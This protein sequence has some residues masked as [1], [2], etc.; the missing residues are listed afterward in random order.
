VSH[1]RNSL[2]WSVGGRYV[3]LVL[4]LV[5]FFILARL[6]TP[7]DIGLYSVAAALIGLV[8]VLREFGIS[9]YLVQEKNLTD[10]HVRTAFT[11]SVMLA[12]TLCLLILAVA[13]VAADFYSAPRLEPVVQVL[14]LSFLLI[15]FSSTA[16]ALLTR[17]MKFQA[18][19][20]I[21]TASS[22]IS[23][24]SALAFAYL[25]HGYWSLVWSSLIATFIS[26]VGN[27]VAA[28]GGLMHRLSLERWRSVL[29]FGG[30]SVAG[31]IVGEISMSFNDLV[32]GRVL[33]MAEVGIL[34]RAQGVMNLFH[35][36]FIGA[37]RNV[38]YP[39]F[40]QVHR[41]G[42]DIERLHDKFVA[43][44][45]V[46]AWP[47]YGLLALFPLEAL[48]LMFGSQW[49][50]AAPLVPIFCA[51]GA[52]AVLWSFV[53]SVLT[54]TGHIGR[55]LRIELVTQPVRIG[56][57]LWCALVYR[58]IEAFAWALLIAYCFHTAVTY[59]FK[60]RAMPTDFGLLAAALRPSVLLSAIALC[61]AIIL[62]FAGGETLASVAPWIVFLLA[63]ILTG[64][65]WLAAMIGLKH[66]L[67]ED[68][69]FL[70]GKQALSHIFRIN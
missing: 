25:G 4:Q 57:L 5:S 3:T 14:A 32:A 60:H 35:R 46:F 42:G 50:A 37:I 69:L 11:I 8:Q 68:P 66:P 26:V 38:A 36:D 58:S 40:A 24:L 16:Q 19:F 44:V 56:I 34:S 61:P 28:R 39:A 31:R 45:A 48:R 63:G 29:S 41:D 2:F 13:P 55:S 49:D 27:A 1:L 15:P 53:S 33:G 10:A 18:L 22:V 23:I 64:S 52:V 43:N 51:A 67:L 59:F 47:F 6:L 21:S 20:W 9:S 30:Q 12:T 54:A 65:A 62:K 17:E 70:K 7:T